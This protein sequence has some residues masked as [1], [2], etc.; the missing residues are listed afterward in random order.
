MKVESLDKAIE[1]F[2]AVEEFTEI[3]PRSQEEEDCETH[4]MNTVKRDNT[5]RYIVRYPKRMNFNNMIGESK[6]TTIRRFQQTE[7]RLERDSNLRSQYSAFMKEYIELVHMKC[8]GEANDP[9]LDEGK[10]VCYLPHHPVFKESSSTTKIRVVFDGSAK[11]S[12]N[13]SLNQALLTG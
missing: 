4:F 8:V 2:W 9:R 6:Q 13:Y 12:T 7:R 3:L 10:T 11:T 1:K 5:G